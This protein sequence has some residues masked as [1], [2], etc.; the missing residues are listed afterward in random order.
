MLGYLLALLALVWPPG[1]L[2]RH[3]QPLFE[4]A[5]TWRRQDWF[6]A[7]PAVSRPGI[8]HHISR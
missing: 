8:A 6:I 7:A 1:P 4:R 2:G 3:A 5:A